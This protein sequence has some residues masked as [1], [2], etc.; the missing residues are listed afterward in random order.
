METIDS[1][2]LFGAAIVAVSTV[3][4]I[5]ALLSQRLLR[6]SAGNAGTEISFG[7]NRSLKMPTAPFVVIAMAAPIVFGGYVFLQGYEKHTTKT[8]HELEHANNVINTFN[9]RSV[10]YFVSLDTEDNKDTNKEQGGNNG[11]SDFGPPSDLEVQVKCWCEPDHAPVRVP[12]EDMDEQQEG[13]GW[14]VYIRNLPP[15]AEV[16]FSLVRKGKSEVQGETLRQ[17]ISESKVSIP[18]RKPVNKLLPPN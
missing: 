11:A 5:L 9:R 6:D 13:R 12:A 16:G 10:T 17:K 15:S 8:E 7:E 4:A 18:W 14:T 2:T 1:S 3:L